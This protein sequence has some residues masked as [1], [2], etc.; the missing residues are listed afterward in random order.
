MATTQKK[1]TFNWDRIIMTL[2]LIGFLLLAVT[3]SQHFD[4][5]EHPTTA[6]QNGIS[7]ADPLEGFTP[8]CVE[9][10]VT[11]QRAILRDS[12]FEDCQSADGCYD[13]FGRNSTVCTSP[14]SCQRACLRLGRNVT[15]EIV[16]ETTCTK[17]T[18]TR[19]PRATS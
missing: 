14:Q 19:I 17:E 11:G 8:T 12:C 16:N 9:W 1:F 3:T 6:P 10:N 7:V 2:L 15:A 5:L 13:L 4:R 18:L